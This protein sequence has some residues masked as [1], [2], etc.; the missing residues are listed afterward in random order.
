MGRHFSQQL[1]LREGNVLRA[2][3]GVLTQSCSTLC[4][5]MDGQPPLSGAFS[6]QEYWSGLPYALAGD[7]PTQGSN[8]H[9]LHWQ[10]DSLSRHHLG[11][12][13]HGGVSSIYQI[14]CQGRAPFAEPP[15]SLCLG[16]T[17]REAEGQNVTARLFCDKGRGI[18][19]VRK[20][21]CEK[22]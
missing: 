16:D 17:H 11:S 6:R 12:P 5:P 9:L 7:L 14:A 3:A 8:P 19:A 13:P 20:L 15:S 1:T 2:V 18:R 10:A 4:S 21:R 22:S